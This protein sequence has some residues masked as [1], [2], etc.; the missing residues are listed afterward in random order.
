MVSKELVKG[1]TIRG[2]LTAF[3]CAFAATAAAAAVA[4]ATV[5][6]ISLIHSPLLEDNRG[7]QHTHTHTHS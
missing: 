2:D 7:R 3:N 1:K 5:N 6:F 4:T